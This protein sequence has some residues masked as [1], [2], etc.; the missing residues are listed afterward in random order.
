MNANDK[1]NEY[2]FDP[3]SV[4][5]SHTGVKDRT[6]W[7]MGSVDR[8]KVSKE[9]TKWAS[10]SDYTGETEAPCQN[11]CVLPARKPRAPSIF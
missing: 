9:A 4:I 11:R 1:L 2:D 10:L 8:S 7:G 5:S 3:T 6:S